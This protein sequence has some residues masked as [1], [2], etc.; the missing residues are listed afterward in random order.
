MSFHPI[1]LGTNTWNQSGPPGRYILSTSTFGSVENSFRIT[2]GR[3]NKKSGVTTAA[4]TRYLESDITIGGLTVR[5]PG[6]ITLGFQVPKGF[7]VQALD[8]MTGQL[9]DLVTLAF[10]NRLLDG[11]Q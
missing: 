9:S 4:V 10:L 11:T 2:G 8:D 3:T 7:P 5:Q 1:V 6:V